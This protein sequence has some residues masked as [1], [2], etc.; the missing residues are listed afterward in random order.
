MGK[1]KSNSERKL[2]SILKIIRI[3]IYARVSPHKSTENKEDGSIKSQIA[4]CKRFASAFQ[5]TGERW[6][7]LEVIYDDGRSGGNDKRNGIQRVK[8]LVQ[9]GQVDVVLVNRLNR[10]F[11]SSQLGHEFDDFLKKHNVRLVSR[12]EPGKA[13]TANEKFIRSM[14]WAMAELYKNQ[15]SEDVIRTIQTKLE[16]GLTHGGVPKPGFD[17]SDGKLFI[18]EKDAAVVR[19]IFEMAE[20]GMTPSQIAADLNDRRI[21]TR[22]RKSKA[23][24][25]T[26]GHRYRPEGVLQILRDPIYKGILIYDGVEYSSSAPTIVSV[27]SWEKVQVALDKRPRKKEGIR[28]LRDKNFFPLKGKLRCGCCNSA[29]KPTFTAK[30]KRDGSTE[31][32]FYYLC[33]KHEKLGDESTCEVGRIPAR[34]VES[35][36]VQSFGE[37]AANPD[38][39]T[40]LIAKTPKTTT[41]RLRKLASEREDIRRQLKDLDKEVEKITQKVLNFAGT[42]IGDKLLSKVKTVTEQKNNLVMEEVRFN[43]EIEALKSD[44]LSPEMLQKALSNFSDAVKMLSEDE[45]RE[46]F[47]LLFKSIIVR[48]GGKATDTVNENTRRKRQPRRHLTLDIKL[49]TEAIQTLF[50]SEEATKGRKSGFNIP[51]EIAHCRKKPMENCGILSPIQKECG[52]RAPK[53]RKKALKTEHE[54]HRAIRWENEMKHLGLNESQLAKRLK[55]SRNAINEVMKW[56]KLPSTDQKHLRSLKGS[57]E[58]RKY[59]RRWRKLRLQ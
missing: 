13:D 3:L 40:R 30:K 59:S 35:L 2:N 39:A 49:R 27:G 28:Q 53:Q 52:H 56:L 17:T 12:M 20:R 1:H 38:V 57:K 46:L 16:E 44:I 9:A 23:G 36:I 33:S 58:I 8:Q 24:N 22:Q 7:V 41:T 50:G 48:E 45:Q 26:G 47:K 10:A 25:V 32:Y 21:R 34:M 19:E 14:N 31:K 11:R 37:I 51:L 4:H 54:I 43:Q 42:A 18:V 15:I 55:L 5:Q 29:M 6:E